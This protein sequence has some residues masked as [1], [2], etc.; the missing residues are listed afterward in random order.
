MSLMQ[1][2][3]VTIKE[4]SIKKSCMQHFEDIGHDINVH[5]VTFE[6]GQA[7]ERTLNPDGS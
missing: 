2:L 1:S 4:I 3:G 6:N 7:R 5:D